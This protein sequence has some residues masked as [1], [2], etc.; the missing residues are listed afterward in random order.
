V[1]I[2]DLIDRFGRDVVV[3]ARDLTCHGTVSSNG[4]NLDFLDYRD[5]ERVATPAPT[6]RQR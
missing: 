1:T 3:R 6:D 2:D 5:G 4:M